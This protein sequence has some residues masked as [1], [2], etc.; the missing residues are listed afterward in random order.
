MTLILASASPRR[1]DLLRQ[2]GLSFRIIVPEVEEMITG[3]VPPQELVKQLSRE[4]AQQVAAKIKSGFVLGADTLVFHRKAILGKPGDHDEAREMLKRLQGDRHEVLTGLCLVDA[5]TGNFESGM[6]ITAVWLKPLSDGQI[7]AYIATGEPLDK[8]GAYGIQG[9]AGLF[10][11][12]IE[13]C[14]FNVVG[15]PLGLL[16]DLLKKTKQPF[17]LN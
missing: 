7:N 14:Y 17:W 10:V 2:A 12:K 11:E 1:A 6:A 4:K 3:K 15:L 5:A 9:K 8:A 16:Y 13:G